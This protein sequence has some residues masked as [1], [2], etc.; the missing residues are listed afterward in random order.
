MNKYR[1]EQLSK[2]HDR[3][4]FDCGEK[5]LNQYLMAMASQH[6]KKGV[7]KT[8]VLIEVDHPETILG[9]VTL[10]ACEIRAECLPDP[11]SKKYPSTVSG[12][13]IGRLAVDKAY[14]RKGLG[15]QLMVFAMS[16]A[17]IVHESIGLIGMI[18]DAK[19]GEAKTYYRQYGFIPLPDNS[20][21]LFLPINT[22]QQAFH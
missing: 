7:S 22:I 16:Q 15:N 21:S 13:K 6:A 20:L 19:S 2:H 12:A 17:L 3:K 5:E 8:F 14:Q 11:Y 18:V 10:T 9:F 4:R 1:I